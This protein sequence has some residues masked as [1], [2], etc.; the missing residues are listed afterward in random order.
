MAL[1]DPVVQVPVLPVQDLSALDPTNRL[2]PGMVPA[3][4]QA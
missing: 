3:G 1:L 4:R 2:P